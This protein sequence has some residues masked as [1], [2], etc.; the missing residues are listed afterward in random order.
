MKIQRNDPCLCGSGKKYKHCCLAAAAAGDESP[1][2]LVWRRVRRALQGHVP[3]M[4]RFVVE[5]YGSEAI[6]EAWTEFVLADTEVELF[7]P[8]TP[9][10]QLFLPWFFH[11]WAPDPYATT[12]QDKSLFDQ[13][14][15]STFLAR[16]ARGMD[17]TLRTYLTACAATPVS[18]HEVLSCNRGHGMLT[19]DVL[20]GQEHAVLER[21]ASASMAVNDILYAQIVRVDGIAMLEASPPF[22]FPPINRIAIIELRD[23][24]LRG[25]EPFSTEL[26]REY[27]IELRE[28]YLSMVEAITNPVM[29]QLQNTDGDALSLQRLVF[30]IDSIDAVFAALKSLAHES[31]EADLLQSAQRDRAGALKRIQFDWSK[32]GNRQHPGWSNTVLGSIDITRKRLYCDV[33]SAERALELRGLIEQRLREAATRP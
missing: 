12:V 33:N 30:D 3:Q 11:C 8:A 17:P 27:D 24:I 23:K 18:Y 29:P 25:A 26:L 16:C 4:L 15:T 28:L 20:T 7:D 14:P 32:A 10:T 9:H 5:T 1:D 19:R 2:Q 21:S 6:H 13:A 22:G 31:T